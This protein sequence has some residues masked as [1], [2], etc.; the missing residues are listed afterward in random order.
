MRQNGLHMEQ[1]ANLLAAPAEPDVLERPP[2]MVGEQPEAT[3]P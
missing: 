1:V 2:E 3:T